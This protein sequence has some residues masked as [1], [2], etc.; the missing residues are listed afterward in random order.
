MHQHFAALAL[1]VLPAPLLAACPAGEAQV[2]SCTT[3]TKKAV[4]VC[5]GRDT[6]SYHYGR[7]GQPPEIVVPE[8]NATFHWGHSEGTGGVMDDLHFRRGQVSYV[9][10][11]QGAADD[12][13]NRMAHLAVEQPGKATSYRQCEEG[14][15]RFNP[16][17]IKA[18][19]RDLIEG[20]PSL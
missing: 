17:A 20:M 1:A 7:P 10:S 6:I 11:Y 3:D 18:A 5:Q 12:P 8:E 4:H 14:S 2:F 16:K 9:L 19:P 13:E 15:I